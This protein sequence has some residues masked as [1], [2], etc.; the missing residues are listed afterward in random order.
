MLFKASGAM[1]NWTVATLLAFIV[2]TSPFTLI[3]MSIVGGVAA[4]GSVFFENARII[5]EHFVEW[6]G[7]L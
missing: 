6:C 5:F 7:S 1:R 2:L 3:G 4:H